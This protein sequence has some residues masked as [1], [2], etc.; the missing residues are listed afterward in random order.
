MLG[1]R[2]PEQ[3]K[4]MTPISISEYINRISRRDIYVGFFYRRP[5][6]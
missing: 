1:L 5:I 2:V 3:L 4:D 6:R